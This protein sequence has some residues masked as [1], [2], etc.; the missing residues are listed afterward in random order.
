MRHAAI[1]L[2]LPGLLLSALLV[3]TAACSPSTQQ[4][5]ANCLKEAVFT[6]AQNAF[7]EMGQ[8]APGL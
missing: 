2:A 6:L 5:V 4:Q 8:Q 1:R 7:T 3:S